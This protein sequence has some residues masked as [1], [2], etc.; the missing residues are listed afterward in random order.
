[1][2]KMPASPKRT[3]TKAC[4]CMPWWSGTTD[5]A[6]IRLSHTRC[7]KRSQITCVHWRKVPGGR[8]VRVRWRNSPLGILIFL[9]PFFPLL[10]LFPTPFTYELHFSPLYSHSLF[11]LPSSSALLSRPCSKADFAQLLFRDQRLPGKKCCSP[12]VQTLSKLPLHSS[13]TTRQAVLTTY[14]N[15][16]I[17]LELCPALRGAR[18]QV[19]IQIADAIINTFVVAI[20]GNTFIPT[21]QP[22][23][24]LHLLEA[25][26]SRALKERPLQW[27]SKTP[28]TWPSCRKSMT[29]ST[30]SSISWLS[31][32][33]AITSFVSERGL[34][35][36]EHRCKDSFLPRPRVWAMRWATKHN[37]AT[38]TIS[39]RLFFFSAQ[40]SFI[41]F[42]VLSD[43]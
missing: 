34:R 20:S 19:H 35:D 31:T 12:E 17:S 25:M 18:V 16:E 41:L 40:W 29:S 4:H 24:S 15:P 10:P 8:M 9:P 2:P 6:S 21:R 42:F 23:M 37:L 30:P 43:A 7:G 36:R 13:R 26:A 32:K 33:L 3:L 38:G 14:D 1:M 22:W 39:P 11:C 28:R 5:R 27:T